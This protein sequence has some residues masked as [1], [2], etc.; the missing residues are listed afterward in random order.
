M[1]MNMKEKLKDILE[2]ALGKIEEEVEETKEAIDSVDDEFVDDD[3][4]SDSD[5]EDVIAEYEA[6]ATAPAAAA[7]TGG[8]NIKGFVDADFSAVKGKAGSANK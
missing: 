7:A 8:V 3:E 4:I 1:S 5:N 6:T 2:E